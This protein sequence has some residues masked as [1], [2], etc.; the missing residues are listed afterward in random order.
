MEAMRWLKRRISDAIYHQLVIDAQRAAETS[1][2]GHCGA[3]LQPARSPYPAHR[4]F[5]SATSRTRNLDATRNPTACEAHA[6][7]APQPPR[8]RAGA[9]KVE[10]PTGRPTLTATRPAHTARR[11]NRALDDRGEPE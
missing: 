4:H 3:T 6:A 9:V 2:G 10:R 11:R 8:R 7:S 5:G 1:P